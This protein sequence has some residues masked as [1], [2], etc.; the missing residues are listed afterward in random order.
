MTQA[1]TPK[2]GLIGREGRA[3]E[4]EDELVDTANAAW[5]LGM[6]LLLTGE[7]GCGK[8]DFAVVIARWWAGQKGRAWDRQRVLQATV[9]GDTRAKDLLY[10]DARQLLEDL[11][12]GGAGKAALGDSSGARAEARKL[13]TLVGER[14]AV[15]G[16]W[17]AS[18]LMWAA[19]GVVV[20]GGLLAYRL[21]AEGPTQVS[22]P[23]VY[24]VLIE[25]TQKTP[26]RPAMQPIAA[27]SFVM[28]SPAEEKWHYRA[29]AKHTVRL[30]RGFR[31]ARTEV[32]QAQWAKLMGNQPSRYKGD[33]LPV[34]QVTW[35]DAVAYVNALSKAEKLEPCYA[36]TCSGK[37][38]ERGF[39]CSK[40]KFK[41]LS[42]PGYRLPTEAEWEY[43][44]RAGTTGPRYGPLKDVAWFGEYSKS[45]T[46]P[47]A[48]KT[49]NAWG[50]YD[51]LGNV[52]EWT[53][54]PYQEGLVEATD[55][56]G[57]NWKAT[58]RRVYRG[59]GFSYPA[60]YCRAALRR[61][62]EPLLRIRS[63]G[64]RPARSFP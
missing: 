1:L 26:N 63:L 22:V 4:V 10:A 51:M 18:R 3:F 5:L 13:K 54:D 48:Q 21:L 12:A 28:G 41:G 27:G 9:R 35:F 20:V 60:R 57:G 45:T 30:T 24:R 17:L 34:E 6:P 44:A 14:R 32:T 25:G 2:G 62:G 53:N 16:R 55:P 29:E 49:P 37:P 61:D 52:W 15:P 38:G 58:S 23:A 8:T 46:H 50:L 47:V 59:C 43:A 33:T 40:V 19:V 39:E 31:L 42:C 7:P 56:L 64:L 36:T 11:I